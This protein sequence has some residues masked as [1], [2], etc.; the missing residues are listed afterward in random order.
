MAFYRGNRGIMSFI[1]K[2]FWFVYSTVSHYN[3]EGSV[4]AGEYLSCIGIYTPFQLDMYYQFYEPGIQV[5]KAV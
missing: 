5:L 3:K 2:G 1:K 4:M